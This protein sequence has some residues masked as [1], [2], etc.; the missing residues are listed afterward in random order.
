MRRFVEGLGNI[1]RNADLTD[2]QQDAI[3]VIELPTDNA[4]FISDETLNLLKTKRVPQWIIALINA[5]IERLVPL[6][7]QRRWRRRLRQTFGFEREDA[8]QLAL[9]TFGGNTQGLLLGVDVFVTFDER[10][11][12]RFYTHLPQIEVKLRRMTSQLLPPYS[13]AILPEVANPGEILSIP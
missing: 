7:Y 5:R 4:L 1:A 6:R 12:N 13:Q 2:E 9:A 11:I 8:H 10:L 3:A